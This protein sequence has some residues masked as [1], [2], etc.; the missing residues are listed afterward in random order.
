MA[1]KIIINEEEF[2]KIKEFYLRDKLTARQIAKLLPYSYTFITESLKRQGFYVNT[3]FIEKEGFKK[4]DLKKEVFRLK[5]ELLNKP[6]TFTQN[7]KVEGNDLRTFVAVCKKTGKRYYD[8]KNQSGA[9]TVHLQSIFPELIYPSN[10]I[11]REYKK[12]TGKYWHEQFFDIIEEDNKIEEKIK[13]KYCEWE[14]ID[15]ENKSGCYTNHIIKSHNMSIDSHLNLFPSDKEYFKKQDNKIQNE[16]ALHSSPENYVECKICGKKLRYLTFTHLKKHGL[17]TLEYLKQFP[18]ADRFSENFIQKTTDILKEAS[19]EIKNSYVS[20]PE[21]SIREFLESLNLEIDGSN[22]KLLHGVEIDIVEHNLKI[23]IEFNGNFYHTEIG[24]GK[25]KNFH[26]RK[27]EMM[28]EIGY[29]LIHIFED[30]WELKNEIVQNKLKHLF[31][32]DNNQT[33]YARNCIIKEINSADKNI[34]L[35]KYHIQGED[36]ANVYIGAY[37]NNELVAIMTFDNHRQ[38]TK[39]ENDKDEYELKRFCVSFNYNITG[40]AGKLLSFFIKNYKPTK[41]ISFADRRWTLNKENNLYTKLGFKLVKI[42]SPDYSYYN[43]KISRFKRFHK[44]S[45]GKSSLKKKFP[46]IYN[47]SKTEWEMVQEL[48]Y[49]RIWDCGKFKYEL[50]F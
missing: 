7:G 20:K 26:L 44:F 4:S 27:T 17:D 33:I 1:E 45:F 24:G 29:N 37:Y 47:D 32:K 12:K 2:L 22:R 14:T 19:Y 50:S 8:Y 10:F 48:G 15:V 28:N 46:E 23:G 11:K 38:M 30:E 5:D 40:I 13:C 49:D 25:K 3:K 43:S 34:F 9:L 21:K 18:D 16:K 39:K 41:I 36:R 31:K 35:N 42:L 6:L